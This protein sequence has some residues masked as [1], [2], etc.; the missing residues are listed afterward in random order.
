[1]PYAW[2]A[3]PWWSDDQVLNLADI[4]DAA[5]RTY[6]IDENRVVVSGV[7][8]GGT[9]AYY[10]AMRETT[11]FAS[12]LP[13]N[14]FWMVLASDGLK[15]DGPLY[16]QQP[17]Q[18][19]VLHRQRRPRSAVSDGPRRSAHRAFQKHG[20][21]ARLRAAAGGRTQH[22]VV[23]A[24]RGSLSRRSCSDH[25]RATRCPDTLT[26]E[27]SDSAAHN[28]AHWLV[29]DT[30]GSAADEARQLTIST[31]VPISARPDF[32]CSRSAAASCV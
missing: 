9:G 3:A 6:N 18:Q 32:G 20:V 17:P 15:I 27:T 8:D 16:R 25:P 22:A 12:F 13:L 10:V 28:R 19:A 21:Y 1:M 29:I 23:A 7:S 2:D 14:G 4:L 11:P 5:K 31:R 30:L 24:G 26:W